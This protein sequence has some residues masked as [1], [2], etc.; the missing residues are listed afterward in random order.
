MALYKSD[1]VPRPPSAAE[2]ESLEEARSIDRIFIIL[3]E[4]K[5]TSYFDYGI[6]EHIIKIHGTTDDMQRLKDYED[7]FQ[8][9]CRRKVFEVPSVISEIMPS[10]RKHF[11]VLMTADMIT[12]LV[13]IKAA[14]RKIADILGLPPSMLTLHE[15]HPG[16]KFMSGMTLNQSRMLPN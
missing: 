6:L 8:K 10:T 15:I 14:K 2:Q 1:D 9:F 7:E 12:T 5:L 3:K 13:D 16:F 11:I 4:F